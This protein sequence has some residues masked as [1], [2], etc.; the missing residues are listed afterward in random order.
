MKSLLLSLAFSCVLVAESSAQVFYTQDF[1]AASTLP[2]GWK[3]QGSSAI[4]TNLGWAVGTSVGGVLASYVA[5]HT[6]FAYVNDYDNNASKGTNYDTLYTAPIDLSAYTTVFMSFDLWF[7]A[8]YVTNPGDGEVATLLASDDGGATWKLISSFGATVLLWEN[9]TVDVSAVAGKSNVKFAFTYTDGGLQAFAI[10]L[11]NVKLFVPKTYDLGITTQDLNYFLQ[12]NTSYT[13]TGKLHNY[14]SAT[15]NAMSLNYS[16]NGGVPVADNQTALSIKELTDYKFTQSIA[17]TP[18]TAGLYKLRIWADQLNGSA[19][20]NHVN[21]TLITTVQVLDSIQV[22]TPLVEEFNQASCDPCAVST[23]NLDSV[24]FNCRNICNVVRYHVSWP[25]RDF[26]NQVT[27]GPLVSTRRAFYNITGVP[28][29]KLD[30]STDIAPGGVR[31]ADIQKAVTKGSPVKI[32]LT[33]TYTPGTNTYNGV[34]DITAY[35]D[36][37]TGL[38]LYAV[39]TVDTIKY[40]ANQSTESIPQYV[41]P[42]VAEA[43]LPTSGGSTV[44]ALISGQTKSLNLKWVKNHAW[45]ASNKTWTYDSTAEHITAFVQNPSNQLVYQSISVPVVVITGID[46]ESANSH[47]AVY[48]NPSA[49][50]ATISVSLNSAEVVKLEVYNI[51]GEKVYTVEESKLSAGTHTILFDG[52]NLNNGVYQVKM[53]AGNEVHTEKILLSK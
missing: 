42:E 14:G 4:P 23:P 10:A 22:K 51:L 35:G 38:R 37:A 29:A 9:Q 43:M 40:A 3:Q 11:D 34:A 25:G 13:I 52:S 16:V 41:F 32:R 6:K 20:E 5:A 36:L 46:D 50:E 21:D 33:A 7:D 45:G 12:K 47:V 53:Y 18:T 15:I 24:L 44:G 39:L 1:Q 17:W 27:E 49:G 8:G 30:G 2:T 19:D 28:D 26:M 48:P 31:S